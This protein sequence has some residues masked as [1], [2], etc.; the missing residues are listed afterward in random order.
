[1]VW[2]SQLDSLAF[3]YLDLLEFGGVNLDVEDAVVEVVVNASYLLHL[4]LTVSHEAGLW[5]L[6]VI[7]DLVHQT[8]QLLSDP[9]QLLVDIP[10]LHGTPYPPLLCPLI[11]FLFPHSALIIFIVLDYYTR[12]VVMEQLNHLFIFLLP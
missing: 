8:H 10:D 6:L 11:P 1:V 7:L 12:G 2:D 9:L 5:I 4:L 3:F